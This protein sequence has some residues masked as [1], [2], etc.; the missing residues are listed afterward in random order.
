LPAIGQ[1]AAGRPRDERVYVSPVYV[2]HPS[3]LY[4]SQHHPGIKG[5][6]GKYCFVLPD[7]AGHK[8]TYIVV[9]GEENKSLELLARYLPDAERVST[10]PLHYQQPYFY[11]YQVPAKARANLSPAYPRQAEWDHR[12]QLL[13]YDLALEGQESRIA[14]RLYYRALAEMDTD[15][16]VFVQLIGPHNPGTNS[17]LWSQADSEPCR[18]YRPTSTW[19]TDEILIDEFALAV[20]ADRIPGEPY[21][22][23]V[24]FYNWRTL[25]RLTVLD[26]TGEPV[27][28]YLILKQDVLTRS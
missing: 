17:P 14:I 3:I 12:I 6:H 19:D 21:A 24:G 13:G 11:A 1:Y 8:T 16:T 15:Y 25:E 2:G 9:A 27:G 28:D 10:G 20:P 4:N 22:L 5:Y 7:Q 23:I 18:G 26:A